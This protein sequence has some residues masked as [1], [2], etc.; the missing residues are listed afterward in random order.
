MC[1]PLPSNVAAPQGYIL[2]PSLS[3]K[4]VEGSRA[5]HSPLK[6]LRL[7][8][9]REI[10]YQEHVPDRSRWQGHHGG[11]HPILPRREGDGVSGGTEILLLPD[12]GLQGGPAIDT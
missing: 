7:V 10:R 12:A 4:I 11:V 1:P 3:V 6:N 9:Y 2:W 5:G 8:N